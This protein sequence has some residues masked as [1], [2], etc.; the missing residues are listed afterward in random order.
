MLFLCAGVP[1]RIVEV[2]R[3]LS[4][5][6]SR[7]EWVSGFKQQQQQHPIDPSFALR[8]VKMYQRLQMKATAALFCALNARKG[9]ET[10]LQCGHVAHCRV[11]LGSTLLHF[12]L[13]APLLPLTLWIDVLTCSLSLTKLNSFFL[14]LFHQQWSFPSR[15]HSSLQ[16]KRVCL[17]SAF[18]LFL[19]SLTL[20]SISL[21]SP[22]KFHPF[23][24]ITLWS[25]LRH[26]HIYKRRERH[27]YQL[28]SLADVVHKN[29]I[30]SFFYLPFLFFFVWLLSNYVFYLRCSYIVHSTFSRQKTRKLRTEQR[31]CT[32]TTTPSCVNLTFV[33]FSS[34]SFGFCQVSK[35][36]DHRTLSSIIIKAS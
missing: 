8:E 5:R 7:E 18:S 36:S 9:K 29:T 19:L 28:N 31:L 2:A 11:T 33:P 15:H 1:A 14:P 22:Y 17:L 34:S 10:A 21:L 32:L 23:L 26:L 3:C 6:R 16:I 20:F 12:P 4:Y 25:P 35:S 24:F 13:L 30:K 27:L